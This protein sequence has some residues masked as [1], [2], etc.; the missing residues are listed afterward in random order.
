MDYLLLGNRSKEGGVS[1]KARLL[2][3]I[4][5]GALVVAAVAPFIH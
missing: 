4:V 5:V 3:L 2:S 1:M